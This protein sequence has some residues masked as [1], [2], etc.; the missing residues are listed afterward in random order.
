REILQHNRQ[1]ERI[2]GACVKRVLDM[3]ERLSR[4]E[5]EKF[6]A[7]LKAFG[8][9]LKEGIVE[10]ASNREL[11]A[12]LLRFAS[13]RGEGDARSVSLVDYIGRMQEG[14]DAIWYVTADG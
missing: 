2:K 13:T 7:F 6:A 9:T 8:N 12:R 5:P 14:Q 4:D 1:L 3:I 10:D 11:I